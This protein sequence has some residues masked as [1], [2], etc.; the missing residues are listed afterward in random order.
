MKKHLL[1]IRQKDKLVF[2]A[3]KSGEKSIETRAG[4]VRYGRIESGDMLVFI[5]GKE[6][7]EKK[8]RKVAHFASIDDLMEAID[9]KEIMPFV[10]S[11]DQAKKL[12]YSFPNY[13][14]R[15]K[16]FGILAFKLE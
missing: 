12:Y 6:K 13:K 2:D 9:F 15:L 1:R 3:I 7:L 5:C 8:V 16:E 11:L 14:E 4:S 10:D